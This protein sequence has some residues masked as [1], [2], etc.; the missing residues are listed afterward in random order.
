[1]FHPNPGNNCDNT[2]LCRQE[3]SVL[4]SMLTSDRREMRDKVVCQDVS[5]EGTAS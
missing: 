4:F 5:R 3:E 1:M 2:V